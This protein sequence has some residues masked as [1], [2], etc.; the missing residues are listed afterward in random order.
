MVVG[1]HGN[2]LITNQSLVGKTLSEISEQVIIQAQLN[3]YL[4]NPIQPK[5]LKLT[6]DITAN[7]Y[8]VTEEPVEHAIAYAGSTIF[9]AN[10]YLQDNNLVI[11]AIRTTSTANITSVLELTLLE[12]TTPQKVFTKFKF[13]N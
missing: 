4:G 12:L 13:A 5:S 6:R 10:Y 9:R 2:N 1:E 11:Q 7:P 8:E 3:D